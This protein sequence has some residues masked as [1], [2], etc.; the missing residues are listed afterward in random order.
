M[1]NITYCY[2]GTFAG[3]LCCVFESYAAHELPIGIVGP[4]DAGLNL[5]GM[6]E[7]ITD[8]KK[9]ER[10]ERSI[11]AKISAEAHELIQLAY[12]TCLPHK[13]ME[14]LR[15]LRQGYHYGPNF[16]RF[17]GNDSLQALETAVKHLL[18]EAH[19]LKGF[20]RF[21]IQQDILVT[22]IGPQNYVLPFLIRHFSERYPE[23][24]ILI[25]DETH[26]MALV[27]RP[28]EANIIPMDEFR[29]APPDA[30]E[31]RFRSLWQEFY[32]SIEIKPRHNE[33]CRS[34]L[35]PKRY[36]TYM[37][38]FMRGKEKIRPGSAL[39]TAIS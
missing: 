39:S 13:E 10:V 19:L 29:S 33:K 15:F 20:I 2:D 21:S 18:N 36:W 3:L 5:F 16:M 9:A 27:Y 22:T 25:F 12:L 4:E 11:P 31:C 38:E 26:H 6:K 30:D 32:D 34:T 1:E 14:I 28:Y 35:M 8:E 24:H 17:A 23:E 7:I 37:T